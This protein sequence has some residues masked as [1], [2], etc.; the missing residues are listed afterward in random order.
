MLGLER[1]ID[2]RFRFAA[3][4]A[5]PLPFLRAGMHSLHG[6]SHTANCCAATGAAGCT[7]PWPPHCT[8]KE[9]SAAEPPASSQRNLNRLRMAVEEVPMA[10]A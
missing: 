8:M 5:G 7:G 2:G 9:Q 1:G 6:S 3:S 4:L 10:K